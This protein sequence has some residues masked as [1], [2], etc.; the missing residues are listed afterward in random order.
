LPIRSG[1]SPAMQSFF[2]AMNGVANNPQSVTAR[3]SL[4]GS[5]QFAVNS[6]RLLISV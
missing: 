5:A 1:A 4:L 2:D 6:F 3:Q